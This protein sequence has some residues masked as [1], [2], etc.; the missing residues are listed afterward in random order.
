MSTQKIPSSLLYRQCYQTLALVSFVIKGTPFVFFSL[1]SLYLCHLF[2]QQGLLYSDMVRSPRTLLC[3]DCHVRFPGKRY[4]VLNFLSWM[5]ESPNSDA[6]ELVA[7][8]QFKASGS[9]YRELVREIRRSDN[10]KLCKS[11]PQRIRQVLWMTMVAGNQSWKERCIQELMMFSF[12]DWMV[13]VTLVSGGQF[14]HLIL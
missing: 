8:M 7:M 4:E 10:A 3:E 2:L 12:L 13:L 5:R 1:L 6:I 11:E 9:K 14:F